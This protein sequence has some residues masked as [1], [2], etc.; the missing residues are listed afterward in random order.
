MCEGNLV[1]L[2][3]FFNR[4]GRKADHVAVLVSTAD[5]VCVCNFNLFI[6][7]NWAIFFLKILQHQ[8]EIVAL[9]V[10]DEKRTHVMFRFVADDFSDHFKVFAVFT[11]PL[12]GK[13]Q[14]IGRPAG[15][16]A[17]SVFVA[18]TEV[19]NRLAVLSLKR[20]D[21]L[22]VLLNLKQEKWI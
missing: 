12:N 5:I 2:P 14:F 6:D 7:G 22:F 19:L 16:D 8:V 18:R 10:V 9:A 21:L 17:L 1:I 15:V 4:R 13:A 11:N 20:T 3:V